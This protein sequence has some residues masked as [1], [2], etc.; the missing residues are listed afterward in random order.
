MPF[1]KWLFQQPGQTTRPLCMYVSAA[2]QESSS[3]SVPP[4]I[5]AQQRCCCSTA[6]WFSTSLLLLLLLLYSMVTVNPC[7]SGRTE[8]VVF[9]EACD[10]TNDCTLMA[11]A[12]VGNN[13]VLGVF[14]YAAPDK[15]YADYS[16]TL[17]DFTLRCVLFVQAVMKCKLQ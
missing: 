10:V 5:H 1:L 11:G 13:A 2:C 16:I 6:W 12:T 4:Y 14:T 17:G 9:G 15:P 3:A 7:T 8:R